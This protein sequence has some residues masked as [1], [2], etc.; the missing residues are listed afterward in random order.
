[1]ITPTPPNMPGIVSDV[2]AG[3][4]T[5]HKARTQRFSR[6][7]SFISRHPKAKESQPEY[8][9]SARQINVFKARP[10]PMHALDLKRVTNNRD[11]KKLHSLGLEMYEVLH[12]FLLMQATGNR[13]GNAEK[14]LVAKGDLH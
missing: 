3:L 5:Q 12:S 2:L 8:R 4:E 7:K 1:M 6:G 14:A 9:D 11:M 10:V 13:S